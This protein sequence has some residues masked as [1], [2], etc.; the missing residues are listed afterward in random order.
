MNKKT[1]YKNK[2]KSRKRHRPHSSARGPF[3][4]PHPLHGLDLEVRRKYVEGVAETATTRFQE[5]LARLV[6]LS[7]EVSPLHVLSI[8]TSYAL[9]A[10]V[11]DAAR[12]G[13]RPT[14]NGG[15]QQGHVEFMQAL[16]L[17]HALVCLL[18]TSP[19]PRD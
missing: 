16:L 10:P 8:L 9:M 13:N 5:R 2:R 6:E 7:G 12:A 1:T 3:L 14:R 4:V 18:Y 17:R 11:D 15:V 19:S